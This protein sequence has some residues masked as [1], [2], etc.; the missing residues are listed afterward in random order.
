LRRGQPARAGPLEGAGRAC[1]GL[2]ADGHRRRAIPAPCESRRARA[3]ALRWPRPRDGATLPRPRAGAAGTGPSRRDRRRAR[4]PRVE[5]GVGKSR[6]VF[7]LTQSHRVEG[8]LVL[9]AGSASYGKATA[10]LPV[11]DLL[12]SYC[13]IGDRDSHR[14]ISEKVT[15]K[16]LTL[17]RALEPTLPAL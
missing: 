1:G 6:L 2:R 5:P 13:R 7:E 16:L 3:L 14:D 17:D 15:G 4:R 11:I 10:Y 12:K 8:W 9:E